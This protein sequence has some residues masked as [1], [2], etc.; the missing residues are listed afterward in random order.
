VQND[1]VV[2]YYEAYY[3]DLQRM[4]QYSKLIFIH[5]EHVVHSAWI[6]F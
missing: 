1:L 2:K 4:N 3:F 5:A 6:F